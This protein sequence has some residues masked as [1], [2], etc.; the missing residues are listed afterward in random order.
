MIPYY[1]LY[2]IIIFFALSA[3][4]QITSARKISKA[5]NNKRL[6]VFYAILVIAIIGLRHPSMGVDLG[7]GADSGYLFSFNYLSERSWSEI[8][9]LSSYL[10][11]EKGYV[12]LNKLVGIFHSRQVFLFV[13][14]TLSLAPVFYIIGNKSN[15]V[16]LSTLIFLGLPCFS[17]SFSALRQA[18]AVGIVFYSIRFIQSKKIILFFLTIVIASLFHSSALTFLVAYPLYYFNQT[19]ITKIISFSLLPVVYLLR[20]PIFLLLCSIF[21]ENPN[22]DNNKSVTLFIVFSLIYLFAILFYNDKCKEEN[23]YINI[24]YIACFCQA[25]GGL[26]SIVMRVGYYF[27]II[28]VLLLPKIIAGYSIIG[29]K[30]APIIYCIIFIAF[31][32]FGLYLL[33]SNTWAMSNPY[34]FFWG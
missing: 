4:V 18:I 19:T 2:A 27:M 14:A 5:K 32:L 8:I 20:R 6:A 31:S 11:Y 22:I 7:Y 34:K 13:C 25:F 21:N 29:K 10:N 30:G 28:L 16:M 33:S 1:I 15:M 12:I 9:S 17:I 23:G 26:N 24:F 3:N